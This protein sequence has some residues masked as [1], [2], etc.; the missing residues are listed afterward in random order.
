[1]PSSPSSNIIMDIR[2]ILIKM[3]TGGLG[4]GVKMRED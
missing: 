3:T 2:G 1:M 4:G